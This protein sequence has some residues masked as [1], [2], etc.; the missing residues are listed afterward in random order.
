MRDKN[1]SCMCLF[2]A[3]FNIWLRNSPTR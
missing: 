1:T 3:R 2:S